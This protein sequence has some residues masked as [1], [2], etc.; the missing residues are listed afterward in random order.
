MDRETEIARLTQALDE[1]TECRLPDLLRELHNEMRAMRDTELKIIPLFFVVAA[2]IL[3]GNVAVQS[4]ARVPSLVFWIA[5]CSSAFLCIFWWRLHKRI[6]EDHATYLELSNRVAAI[7]RKLK[8]EAFFAAETGFGTGKG[9][10]KNQRLIAVTAVFVL[11]A[12]AGGITIR[13]V[14]T[15]DL[16]ESSMH[17]K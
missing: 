13:L 7:R 2:F 11:I 6:A 15:P 3:S 8:A 9:Y 5:L 16:I 14:A 10:Q 4:Q 17:E 1:V 12:L